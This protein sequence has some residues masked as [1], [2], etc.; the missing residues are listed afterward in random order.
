MYQLRYETIKPVFRGILGPEYV[1]NIFSR[2][3]NKTRENI[4]HI[5]WDLQ[6]I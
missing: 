5:L 1:Q 6:N 3:L 4:L 2:S